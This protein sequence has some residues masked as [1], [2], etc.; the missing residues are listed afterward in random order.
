M[1]LAKKYGLLANG[2]ITDGYLWTMFEPGT[3]VFINVGRNERA[4]R[5]QSYGYGNG[6]FSV[7]P[8][9][10]HV[11]AVVCAQLFPLNSSQSR[12]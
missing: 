10:C 7:Y 8:F 2:V 12:S 3:L 5:V 1:N 11:D 4:M 9:S 6:S